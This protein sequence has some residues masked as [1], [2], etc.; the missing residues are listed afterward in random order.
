MHGPAAVVCI[1]RSW[2]CSGSKCW[3]FGHG[4][5]MC[6]VSSKSRHP[7]A[8]QRRDF[9]LLERHLL[10]ELRLREAGC[11]CECMRPLRNDFASIAV[12]TPELR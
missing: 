11:K 8:P 7:I 6:C 4:L 10:T 9:L 2:G 12:M 3:A 5:L 1:Y